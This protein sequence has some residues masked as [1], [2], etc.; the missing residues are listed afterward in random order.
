MVR[1]LN[2]AGLLLALAAVLYL[3]AH[4]RKQEARIDALREDMNTVNLYLP[5][6]IRSELSAQEER[7]YHRIESLLASK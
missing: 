4:V 2:A 7:L 1:W 5:S 3:W 6:L